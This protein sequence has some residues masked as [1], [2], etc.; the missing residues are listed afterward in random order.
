[1]DANHLE[2]VFELTLVVE[3]DDIVGKEIYIDDAEDFVVVID[4]GQSKKAIFREKLAG[5]RPAANAGLRRG[6][7]P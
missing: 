1:M 6:N 4:Y 3:R 7:G 2:D 5:A